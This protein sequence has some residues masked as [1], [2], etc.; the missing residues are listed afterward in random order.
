MPVEREEG[1]LREGEFVGG[2]RILIDT[3]DRG[4]VRSVDG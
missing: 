4:S 1:A 3:D 2:I